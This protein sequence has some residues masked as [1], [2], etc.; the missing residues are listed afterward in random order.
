DVMG[1]RPVLGRLIGAADDGPAAA[2]VVVLTHRF[3]ST[4]FHGDPSVLGRTVRLDDGFERETGRAAVV[5][6]VL[7]PSIP[8]PAEPGLFANVITSPHHLSATMVDGRVHRMTEVF[9]RLS[10]SSTLEAAEAQL[11]DAY[12][13]IKRDYSEAY[14]ARAGFAVSMVPLRAQLTTNARTVLIVLL[15]ASVLI[16]VIALSN[17]ANLILART[18]RR[19]S[20]LALRAAVGAHRGALR[21]TLLAESLLLCGTGALLG[22]ALAWP[23]VGVL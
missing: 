10:P 17:V 7:E 1:L 4:T 9:A 14:P 12:S 19:E 2:G 13:G 3:W 22:A 21:A 8:Y 6:G 23:L 18:V 11:Q 16:F 15:A 5:V 20:E